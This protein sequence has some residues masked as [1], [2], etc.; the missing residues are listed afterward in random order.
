M[1]FIR[2]INI[3][4]NL[5]RINNITNNHLISGPPPN[6]NLL[7]SNPICDSEFTIVTSEANGRRWSGCNTCATV[8]LWFCEKKTCQEILVKHMK[9]CNLQ[10]LNRENRLIT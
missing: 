9:K 10:K 4:N 5:K 6:V 8:K 7:C 2:Y 3:K 1:F